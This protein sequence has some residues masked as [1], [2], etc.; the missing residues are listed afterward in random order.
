M[1]WQIVKTHTKEQADARSQGKARKEIHLNFEG[2]WRKEDKKEIPTR[3]GVYLVYVCKRKLSQNGI[4]LNKLIYI[5]EAENASNRIERHE[6][7]PQ[8][9][10]HLSPGS[11]LCFSFA[12]LIRREDR[13]RAK[14]ALI[15]HHEPPCNVENLVGSF[16]MEDITVE[17]TGQCYKLCSP[18]IARMAFLTN[19][20][21]WKNTKTNG[22]V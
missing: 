6:K 3:S 20:C 18:V 14:A 5:G 10:K 22:E 16:P 7:W 13:K 17:S 15:H 12:N 2:Y 11:E 21:F 4:S 8:W 19:I 1:A 9:Q